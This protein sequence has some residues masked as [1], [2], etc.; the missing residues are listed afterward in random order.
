MR[1][2]VCEAQA[3]AHVAATAAAAPRP[4]CMVHEPC[5]MCYRPALQ[6]EQ[7]GLRLGAS[8]E[9]D[10]LARHDRD[11]RPVRLGVVQRHPEPV[12][13]DVQACGSTGGRNPTAPA[14]GTS[15]REAVCAHLASR[16]AG[17]GGGDSWALC[18]P[19]GLVS[20][21]GQAP[22]PWLSV[23]GRL[24]ERWQDC[25]GPAGACTRLAPGCCLP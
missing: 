24:A 9:G 18:R 15:V 21:D 12:R 8:V 6:V 4:A 13:G 17:L 1:L 3:E 10:H 11:P 2:P 7:V 5:N 25:R 16:R 14:S 22:G 19:P 23:R 20:C